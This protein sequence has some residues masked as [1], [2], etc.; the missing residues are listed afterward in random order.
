MLMANAASAQISMSYG[1]A[2]PGVSRSL[3]ACASANDALAVAYDKI[4]L[5]DAIAIVTGGSEATVIP[6]AMGGFGS[7]K[8]LSTRNDEPERA[9]AGRSIKERDGF[10]LGEGAGDPGARG[11]R[12]RA[13]ARRA[14]LR[15]MLGYGQSADAFHIAQPDPE[16]QGR[17]A[18]DGARARS[19]A[20]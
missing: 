20:A 3:S 10:V 14:H 2:R 17:H 9:S 16:S 15:R 13:R 19:A 6:T 4:V 18:R 5:G 8:A 7:M 1:L 12:V 11:S